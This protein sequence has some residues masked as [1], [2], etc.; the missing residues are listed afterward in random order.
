[1]IILEIGRGL[2][3]SMFAYAAAKLLANHHNTELK[4]DISHI[5]SWPR[6]EKNGGDW[7]FTLGKFKISSKIATRKEIRKFAC[8]TKCRPI[9][10][11]FRKYHLFEKNV[12]YFPTHKSLDEF[13]QIPNNS[14][15]WGYFG[16]KKFSEPILKEL[17]EEFTLK[18]EFS[19]NIK[20]DLEKVSKEESVSI[21]VRRGDLLKLKNA[22]VLGLSYYKNAVELMKKKLKEPTFY[23]FSDDIN[24]CKENLNLGVKLN[25]IEGNESYE[26]LE[27]MKSCKN[28]ILANSAMSWW[29]G[30]LN[31]NPKRIVIAPEKFTMFNNDD[32][33]KN[34]PK[35]WILIKDS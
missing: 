7:D 22:L 13:Y 1:M 28:N 2:G 3:N 30:Y 8:K 35:D 25:F 34:L 4:L 15:L 11:V 31:K 9:D 21:H 12:F 27:L 24:W 14:Y 23:V 26:D 10:K 32:R 29:T 17:K 5:Q 20:K 33:D 19:Q 18:E 6:F 16:D